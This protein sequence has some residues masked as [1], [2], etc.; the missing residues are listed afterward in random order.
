MIVPILLSMIAFADDSDSDV[1]ATAILEHPRSE[2]AA[3]LR[4]TT[5]HEALLPA[6]CVSE[7]EHGLQPT[8]PAR[9]TYRILSFKRRL[10]AKIVERDPDH[11][12]ELDHEGSKG[13]VTRWV[14]DEVAPG[15][16]QVTLTTY[17][18]PPGWPFR[19]YY[20]EKVQPLWTE[21]YVQALQALDDR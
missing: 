17:L 14:L 4:S 11:V 21:C 10:T 18:N 3:H 7:W 16:T 2:L 12:I 15:R 1:T 19:R 5:G 20:S 8:G 13:F 6:S 9:M